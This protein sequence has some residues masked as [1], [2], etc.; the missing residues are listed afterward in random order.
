MEYCEAMD[1]LSC[2]GLGAVVV[3]EDNAIVEI[4][5]TGDRLLH[6]A[7]K[8][9]GKSL[10]LIA[11]FLCLGVGDT[12]YANIDFNEYL[13][14]CPAPVLADLP[15]HTRLIVFRDATK[16]IR[17]DMLLKILNQINEAVI[18]CDEYSRI[19]LLNDAAAKMDSLLLANISGKHISSIYR[20]A[21]G[22]YLAV[23]QVIA[24]K[25]PLLNLR[26]HYTTCY[27]K[28]VDIVCNNY[29]IIEG[30]HMLGGFSV[31][32]DWSKIDEL[33]KQIIDLQGKLLGRSNSAKNKAGNAWTVKYQFK[34]IIHT[35]PAMNNVVRQCQQVARSD[36][37]VMIYGE[38]GTG[39]ELLTQSIHNASRRAGRPFLAINCAAI[40]ENLL[41][42]LLFGTERGAY[43]GAERREGLFEQANTG[44]LFL[45]EI[46]SMN[47]ALQAKLMR[48]LQDG[49]VRRVGGATEIHVDVRVLSNINIPPYQ[50]IEE[51]RLRPDLFYRLGAVN[52]NIPPLRERKEDILLLTKNF[53]FDFNRKLLKNVCDIDAAT[54][55]IFYA[56]DWPGNVRELQHAIEHAMNVL[57]DHITVITPDYIPEHILIKANGGV[58]NCGVADKSSWNRI[59]QDVESRVLRKALREN[60]GNISKT[61]RDLGM[62]RQ[63]LQYRIKRNGIDLKDVLKDDQ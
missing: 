16:D 6:G 24:E 18:L 47:L 42:S 10:E 39:K 63:N 3:A 11:P 61:A 45:D 29:P 37:S 53:I 55:E 56:Y 54:M 30:D 25:R 5:E 41:E 58:N 52:I 35:S 49:M 50:A 21:N 51:N 27:G 26:Q 22:S 7:G 20:T 14:G 2:C 8:L 38:T 57:R 31:M 62:S 40:P 48:V 13:L 9:K 59:L 46:N 19:L 36:S 15:P 12:C 23:P 43:T 1:M 4:N 33:N 17:H 34:D 28:E 32:E 60:C 44:T